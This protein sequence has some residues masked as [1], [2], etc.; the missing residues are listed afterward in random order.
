MGWRGGDMW[1]WRLNERVGLLCSLNC[2]FFVFF[3]QVSDGAV[4]HTRP[5]ANTF[6]ISH[7]KKKVENK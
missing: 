3:L 7:N 4:I 6:H 5:V 1:V 2:F